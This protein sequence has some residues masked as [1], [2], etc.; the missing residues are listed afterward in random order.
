MIV[1]SYLSTFILS[2]QRAS[3]NIC[4]LFKESMDSDLNYHLI[5]WDHVSD[6]NNFKTIPLQDLRRTFQGSSE[7]SIAEAT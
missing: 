1:F 6:G 2:K 4:Q 3:L 5:V 7:V